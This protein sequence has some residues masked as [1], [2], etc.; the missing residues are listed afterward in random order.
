MGQCGAKPEWEGVCR[1]VPSLLSHLQ[2]SRYEAVILCLFLGMGL[3]EPAYSTVNMSKHV[4]RKYN[5][6]GALKKTEV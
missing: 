5:H 3:E 2:P 1:K 6:I 4:A